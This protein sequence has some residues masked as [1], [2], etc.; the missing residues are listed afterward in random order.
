MHTPRLL[1][2]LDSVPDLVD[3]VHGALRDAIVDGALAPGARLTQEELARR[4]AVSRQPV[5]QALRLLKADGLVNDAPGRGL[6]VTPLDAASIAA[7]YQVR[8]ALDARARLDPAL[9]QAGREA[10]R[11]QSV[12]GLIDA[13]A[14]FHDAI[15]R[16]SGNPLIA[17]SAHLHWRHIRRAMGA[18]LARAALRETV[19][20]EH[21]AIVD[22]IADGDE[23]R[24][25]EL[26]AGHDQRASDFIT[27]M[28]GRAA[29]AH[30]PFPTPHGDTP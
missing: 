7:V 6:Q 14:A 17:D 9:V 16:A 1:D 29:D 22:A 15:Y 12:R 3:R 5:L 2:R 20:D 27:G 8:E 30:P 10:L 13:D 11:A 4:L 18:V 28:L 24:A 21:A 25:A 23:A 26:M 19:W